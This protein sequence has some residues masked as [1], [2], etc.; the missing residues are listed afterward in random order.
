[1]DPFSVT[2]VTGALSAATASM[3]SEMGKRFAESMGGF[4][5]RVFGHETPAPRGAAERAALAAAIVARAG[6]EPERAEELAALLAA[7]PVPPLPGHRPPVLLPPATRFFTDRRKQLAALRQEATRPAAGRPRLVQLAGPELIGTTSLALHFGHREPE[8]F[9]DGRLYVDLRSGR[10]GTAPDAATVLGYLLNHLGLPEDRLPAGEG[11]RTDLFRTLT[12]DLRALVILDHATSAGQ[13]RALI[14]PAPGVL[15]VVTARRPLTGLDALTVEV[16][17]LADK[18]AKRLLGELAGQ[19]ALAAGRARV[20]A[21]LA[22]YGGS[23]YAVRAGARYLTTA[24][25][26]RPAVEGDPVRT[27]I[28]DLYQ[29]LDAPLAAFYRAL[30]LHPWPAV[31]A[32][33]AAPATGVTAEQAGEQLAELAELGLLEQVSARRYRYRPAARRHGAELAAATDSPAARKAAVAAMVEG[34]LRFAVRADFAALPKRWHVGPLFARLGPGRYADEGA[35]IAAL[36]E[37]LPNLVEAVFAAEEQGEYDTVCQLVEALWAW[38]LKV[39]RVRELLPALRAGVRAAARLQDLDRRMVGRMHTQLAF[40]LLEA[41]LYEEA[42]EQLR[43]AAAAA[44]DVGHLL[45]QATAVESLGL[46]HLRRWRFAPA[47]ACFE[48]ADQVLRRIGNGEG[49]KDVPR[50]RALLQRHR[51]RALSG[52][53]EFARAAEL[54]ADALEFFRAGLGTERYNAART[55]GDLAEVR[56]LAGSRDQALAL[57]EEADELLAQEG[58]EVHLSALD[59]LRRRARATRG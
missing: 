43:A 55:L 34:Y 25:P 24:L 13:V 11:D 46:L 47:L 57:I 59:V 14:S 6:Q 56:L 36:G 2:L 4:V 23:P 37:E 21:L 16:G 40:G 3:G 8:R 52:L 12:A 19:E 30:A 39:G 31:D 5:H 49:A 42:E 58:A 15:T 18:D 28:D 17:P 51:G 29:S 50:A 1:M 53:G 35:A 44:Q 22:R 45:G 27:A 54:L 33:G 48:E 10:L 9:P 20:P 26:L 7:Q 41:E 38:Q 32:A